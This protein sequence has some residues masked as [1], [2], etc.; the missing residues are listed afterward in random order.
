MALDSKYG[1]VTFQENFVLS[2]STEPVF[3][4]RAQDELALQI[5]RDYRFAYRDAYGN[6]ADSAFEESLERVYDVF[7]EW[8]ENNTDQVKKPD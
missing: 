8:Q 6:D 1:E 3:V 2:E 5:I 7:E 4:I